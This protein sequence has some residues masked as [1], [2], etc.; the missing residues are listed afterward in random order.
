[1]SVGVYSLEEKSQPVASG[2]GGGGAVDSVFGR[3]GVVTAQAGDYAVADI[4]GLSTALAGKMGGSTGATDNRVLRSDGTG[5]AT[6]QASAVTMDDSGNCTGFGTIA[7]G[8]VTITGNLVVSGTV[9]G[10]DVSTDGT[11]LDLLVGTTVPAKAI[12]IASSTDNNVPRFDGTGG[13]QLQASTWV[14]DDTGNVTGAGTY[15]AVNV[16]TLASSVATNTSDIAARAVGI[17]SVVDNKLV[18]FDG[19][20]G[21]QLQDS[22]WVV[23]D[24]G[25]VT[26]AGTYN[27]TNIGTLASQV[28]ANTTDISN[29]ADKAFTINTQTGTTYTLV[30]SDAGKLIDMSNA[31]AIALTIPANSS[32]AF[33]VGTVITVLQAGAGQVTVG[34]TTD[35][36][37]GRNGLK[38]AGQWA[39]I[40]LIKRTSTSWVLSGDSAT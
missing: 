25:N 13:K 31:A 3:T 34:I 32:V 35:T 10:R 20:G 29:K 7:C 22:T 33:P 38:T 9:D 39:V 11:A 2:G 8:T 36:L 15:N 21:K 37:N 16:G 17:A 24:S 26:G 12:G 6:V 19:T 4:T 14:I 30:L 28:S 18:R 40:S 1:M 23:D 5:G 27:G